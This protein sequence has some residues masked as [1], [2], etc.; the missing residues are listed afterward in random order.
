MTCCP[1]LLGISL[2]LFAMLFVMVMK[3]AWLI[4]IFRTV[5]SQI[6]ETALMELSI[7]V[8]VRSILMQVKYVTSYIYVLIFR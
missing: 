7:L 4:V 1:L 5:L 6:I 3:V 8:A 2:L